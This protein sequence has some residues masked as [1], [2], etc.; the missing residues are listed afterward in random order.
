[1]KRAII[2][3]SGAGGATVAKEL[4]GIYDVTVLEAGKTFQPFPL[5]IAMLAKLRRTGLLFDERQI[6]LFFPT[7]K[8]T[9]TPDKMI[10]VK[11]IG[12]GGTTTISAGNALRVDQ[13]L[14]ELGINLDAEFTEIIREIPI[15]IEH[16]KQWRPATKRLF[17][18]CR[19]LNLSPA[20]TP[21]MGEY[22]KCINCGR[23]VLGCPQNVKWDSRQFL[24]LAIEKG[25]GLVTN[26]KVNKVIIKNGEVTGVEASNGWHSTFYPADLVVLAAGGMGTPVI[27][28]NSGIACEDN[29]FVDP[30]FC[31]ATEWRESLQN[32][33][34]SMPFVVQR[35]GYI[36]SPYFDYLSFFF[37]K[38]WGHPA[39]NILSL[40]IK[41]AD[42]NIGKIT[43]RK[44]DKI[45]TD[46][47]YQKLEEGVATC[48]KIF[49]RMG[50]VKERL[51][52]GTVNAGHP[53]G[54]LPLTE[55]ESESFHH[56]RLPKNLYIADAT[57]F[58]DSLGNPP[59]LTIIAMAKR[60]HKIILH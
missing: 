57:L 35:N 2:V 27:L 19:E 6:Q 60:I 4:Q 54:M 13:Q 43:D 50:I 58:P 53:G 5:N 49:E 8:I 33:E 17:E 45:L 22:T 44:I 14:K 38:Q 47:D 26:S 1:M 34:I 12:L 31:V 18:I 48:T 29:F 10:L 36:L 39:G 20:P 28:Q 42:K 24:K 40:M 21:K 15:S 9:R 55:L 51:F 7:M 37:N 3:G 52:F 25:A 59:I 23:C 46:S 41:L 56:S 32:K 11:G 30:V 16:Q